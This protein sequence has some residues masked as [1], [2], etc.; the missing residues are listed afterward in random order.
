MNSEHSSG[1]ALRTLLQ[2]RVVEAREERRLLAARLKELETQED[3]YLKA[4]E[5][6]EKRKLPVVQPSEREAHVRRY[7]RVKEFGVA[8]NTKEFLIE[9]L[10]DDGVWSLDELKAKAQEK[11]M[12]INEATSL[13]RMLH[14]ALLG[15]L[16][17]GQVN[18]LGDGRWQIRRSKAPRVLADGS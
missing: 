12:F 1:G 4:L 9:M 8:S 15:L 2:R 17:S 18:N 7:Q 16:Q 13:G 11:Q 6:E 5:A 14:G 10:G 3:V